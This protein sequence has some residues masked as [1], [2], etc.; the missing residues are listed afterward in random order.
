MFFSLFYSIIIV[1][2]NTHEMCMWPC[3]TAFHS[4]LFHTKCTS[5]SIIFI[6]IIGQRI[7]RRTNWNVIKKNIYFVCEV[8]WCVRECLESFLWQLE[9]PKIVVIQIELN[10]VIVFVCVDRLQ[11]DSSTHSKKK[12]TSLAN[13]THQRTFVCSQDSFGRRRM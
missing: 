4:E 9:A 3:P 2:I 7:V 10:L 11:F 1:N 12:L 8:V 5:Y 6:I 13:M